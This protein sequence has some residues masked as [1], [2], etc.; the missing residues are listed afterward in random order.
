MRQHKPPPKEVSG[1]PRGTPSSKKDDP[2]DDVE[3]QWSTKRASL[4]AERRSARFASLEQRLKDLSVGTQNAD[5]RAGRRLRALLV[6][7]KLA[8]AGDGET[9]CGDDDVMDVMG[10]S[11]TTVA[12]R[13]ESKPRPFGGK[14]RGSDPYASSSSDDESTDTDEDGLLSFDKGVK[15]LLGASTLSALRAESTHAALGRTRAELE[16][17]RV[18]R[19]VAARAVADALAATKEAASLESETKRLRDA[20]AVAL[21]ENTDAKAR[22]VSLEQEAQSLR[23]ALRGGGTKNQSLAEEERRLNLETREECARAWARAAAAEQSLVAATT[24]ARRLERERDA[25]ERGKDACED[26]RGRA[27]RDAQ[28]SVAELRRVSADLESATRRL[29]ARN[30]KTCSLE[31]RN[32][33]QERELTELRTLLDAQRQDI[34]TAMRIVGEV[35]ASSR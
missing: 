20:L 17:D 19:Q 21:R 13:D 4:A 35:D 15:T 3:S 16:E 5:E 12:T 31:K 24:S 22:A 8:T 26:R 18:D 32:T 14:I 28:K 33:E 30:A 23:F 11:E 2:G 7:L 25:L 6:A 9:D 29:E 34:A 27:E 1:P 10:V